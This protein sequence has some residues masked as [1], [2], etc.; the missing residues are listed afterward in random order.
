MTPLI[1]TAYLPSTAYMAYLAQHETVLVERLETFPKQTYRNRCTIATGN[2]L[3]TLTVPVVRTEGNHTRTEQM[4]VSYHEPW[5]IRHWRTIVSAY[6]TAPYFLYYRDGLEK[7]LMQRFDTLLELNQALLQ[8]LLQKLKIDCRV[9]YTAE[10]SPITTAA[11]LRLALTCKSSQ[12]S[13]PLPPYSQVFEDRYGFQP[14]LSIIDLLF[15]LG[16]ESKSYLQKIAI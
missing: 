10:F 15:N 13:T 4:R 11:D 16:P 3:Q 5:N 1:S 6:N 8:Y 2:G 12:A 7:L 9:E 14:N